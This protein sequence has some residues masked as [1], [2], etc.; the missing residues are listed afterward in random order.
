MLSHSQRIFESTAD[1][2]RK[3][4]YDKIYFLMLALTFFSEMT[5]ANNVSVVLI[6]D[7]AVLA[8]PI[9]NNQE[10]LVDVRKEGK[11]CVGSSPEI[12]NNKDYYYLRESVYKKLLK[13]Q[14]QLPQKLKFCL[15][16]GYRSLTLQ[17]AL[18]QHHLKQIKQWHPD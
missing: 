13:A 8:I 4:S 11:I 5:A 14:E 12:L 9:Q 18:F 16:E 17:D 15:Y 1:T 6:S 3:I 10:P 7:P 2:Q